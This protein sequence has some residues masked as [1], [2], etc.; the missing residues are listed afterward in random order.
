[1]S[2]KQWFQH[3]KHPLKVHKY[4]SFCHLGIGEQDLGSKVCQ[5][6]QCKYVLND[7]SVSHF[8]EIPTAEQIKAFSARSSFMNDIQYRFARKGLLLDY[9]ILLKIFMMGKFTKL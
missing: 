7:S 6:K 3:I 1:M 5:N 4:C 8:I 2:F 9:R